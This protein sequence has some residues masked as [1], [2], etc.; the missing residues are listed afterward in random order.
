MAWLIFLRI[1]DFGPRHL[2]LHACQHL[3]RRDQAERQRIRSPSLALHQLSL[4]TTPLPVR[5]RR[6]THERYSLR[7]QPGRERNI[8]QARAA[9]VARY[10][11][12]L[13]DPFNWR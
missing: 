6:F 8:G 11:F 9:R 1:A 2:R 4:E 7:H 5:T 13:A 3:A 12:V 10:L